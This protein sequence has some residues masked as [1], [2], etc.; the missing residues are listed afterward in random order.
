MRVCKHTE[1]TYLYAL[2]NLWARK[3]IILWTTIFLLFTYFFPLKFKSKSEKGEWMKWHF[4]RMNDHF[5]SNLKQ[6]DGNTIQDYFKTSLDLMD[7]SVSGKQFFVCVHNQHVHFVYRAAYQPKCQTQIE[8]SE[9]IRVYHKTNRKLLWCNPSIYNE[10]Q[11]EETGKKNAEA[12]RAIS[13][14][15]ALRD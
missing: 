10:K 3:L 2:Q 11:E 4:E 9:N 5:V 15:T 14:R 1:Y 12:N 6:S 7:V 8:R 13:P